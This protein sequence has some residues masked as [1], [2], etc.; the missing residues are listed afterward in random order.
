MGTQVNI[1]A[2]RESERGWDEDEE[3]EDEEQRG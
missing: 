2:S 1:Q 3:D